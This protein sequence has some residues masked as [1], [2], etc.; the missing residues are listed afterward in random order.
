MAQM[1][2]DIVF[3]LKEQ[4]ENLG[5]SFKKIVEQADSANQELQK[6]LS[7]PI[8]IKCK[9]DFDS[10]KLDDFWG[11]FETIAEKSVTNLFNQLSKSN[12]IFFD[13]LGK[14]IKSSLLNIEN[15][16]EDFYD[17]FQ[18]T[19]E[20][21]IDVVDKAV[22]KRRGFMEAISKIKSGVNEYLGAIG[23]TLWNFKDVLEQMEKTSILEKLPKTIVSISGFFMRQP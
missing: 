16:L 11:K 12:K 13:D 22:S 3:N 1:N 8:N 9:L 14:I 23:N 17:D 2:V 20:K 10:L 4:G 6:K 15:I 21:K 18:K 7:E 5:A 19:L